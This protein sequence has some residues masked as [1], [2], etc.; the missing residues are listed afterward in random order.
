MKFRVASIAAAAAL[1]TGLASAHAHLQKATPAEGSTLTASPPALELTFSEAARVTALW[2]QRD[3]EP[4][5]PL[6]NLP[7]TSDPRLRVELP[8]LIPGAYSVTWRVLGA[9]GHVTSGALHFRIAP[10]SAS[11]VPGH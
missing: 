10:A 4:K 6:K 2:I 8:A 11:S 3:Q 5:Q 9:D 1:V 7:T